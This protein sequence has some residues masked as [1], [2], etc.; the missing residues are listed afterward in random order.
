MPIRLLLVDDSEVYSQ[1]MELVLGREP[2]LEVV[3][4][5]EDGETALRVC[6]EADLDLVLLDF[7]LPGA[8]GAAV[9]ASVHAGHPGVRVVCLTAEASPEERAAVLAAGASAVVEKGDLEELLR[10]IR[11]VA[12]A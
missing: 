12:P 2:D 3:A 4:T 5:A 7:R 8:D 10:A 9:T 6:E 1:T 11:E